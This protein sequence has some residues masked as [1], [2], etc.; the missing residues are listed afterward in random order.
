MSGPFLAV[1][2]MQKLHAITCPFSNIFKFS[3]FLPKFSN[4]LHC[5]ALFKDFL[6]IFCPFSEKLHACPYFL[7][8]LLG[9]SRNGSREIMQ[10]FWIKSTPLSRIR[11]WNQFSQLRWTKTSAGYISMMSQALKRGWKWSISS[12]AYSLL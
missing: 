6:A 10:S 2:S 11:K 7:E 3:K 8:A 1:Y 9:I 4:I 5:F 12:P